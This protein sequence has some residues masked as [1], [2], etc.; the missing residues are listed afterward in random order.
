MTGFKITL[1]RGFHVGFV[2]GWTVSVQFGPGNYC[3]HYDRDIGHDD[4]TCGK[5]GSFDAETACWGPSGG[6][7]VVPWCDGDTVQWR[8]S[9]EQVLR[10]L[11]WAA[12]QP[13]D[14]GA[15]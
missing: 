11:N 7:V 10:L 5:E 2:N 12:S 3:E 15:A 6:L 14:G 9:P 4:A 13:S 8:Q 1:G